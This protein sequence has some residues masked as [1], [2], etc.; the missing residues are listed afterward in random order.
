MG[1]LFEAMGRHEVPIGYRTA[2][3]IGRLFEAIGDEVMRR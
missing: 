3:P 1:R 2:S